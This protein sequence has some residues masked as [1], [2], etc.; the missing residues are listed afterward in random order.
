MTRFA[1]DS[2]TFRLQRLRTE[3]FRHPNNKSFAYE[4]DL[5]RSIEDRLLQ[6]FAYDYDLAGNIL[7]IQDRT[8]KSGF[9]NNREAALVSDPALARLLASGDA[10]LRH[11][12]YDP[13]YRLRSATGR[14]CDT[15]PPRRPWDDIVR[16]TDLDN[17]RPYTQTYTYDNAGNITRL[18]H[19][20]TTQPNAD[21][22]RNFTI[23]PK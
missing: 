13:I 22:V 3:R 17:T 15:P 18:E 16:C 11:F 8:P 6:D 20:A 2:K 23:V 7:M 21:F 14:E 10:L 4:P 5:S 12:K 19:K 1:Y 9:R